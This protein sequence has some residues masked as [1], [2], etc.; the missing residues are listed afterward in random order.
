M[1][2]PG[3]AIMFAGEIVGATQTDRPDEVR[4]MLRPG[5]S[6]VALDEVSSSAWRQY[7]QWVREWKNP[8]PAE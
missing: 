6:L 7:E 1:A 5:Y 2:A 8:G 4:A 3:Y